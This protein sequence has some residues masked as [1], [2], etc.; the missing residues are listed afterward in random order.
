MVEG[1]FYSKRAEVIQWML[2]GLMVKSGHF[3]RVISRVYSI[4]GDP[5]AIGAS[6][7]CPDP[8]LGGGHGLKCPPGD[9]GREV[10]G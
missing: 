5:G 3:T 10:N 9:L 7:L 6:S 4:R 1:Q 8:H 2:G